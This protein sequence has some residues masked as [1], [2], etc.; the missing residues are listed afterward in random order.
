[1]RLLPLPAPSRAC[2]LR[3]FLVPRG[4]TSASQLKK[5]GQLESRFHN[6]RLFGRI[7]ARFQVEEKI[8]Y[9]LL[10]HDPGEPEYEIEKYFTRL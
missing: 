10:I 9:F 3:A 8:E 7:F 1:M 4:H 6:F 5:C 2:G